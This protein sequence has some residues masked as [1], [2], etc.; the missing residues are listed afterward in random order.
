MWGRRTDSRVT[1]RSP[2]GELLLIEALGH[3]RIA[4]S[5]GHGR[6]TAL[7]LVERLF[8]PIRSRR[9]SRSDLAATSR[10]LNTYQRGNRPD[11]Q[12]MNASLISAEQPGRKRS[13]SLVIN[14]IRAVEG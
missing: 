9:P 6:I 3:L 4:I 13:A 14:N 12:T 11:H 8:L 1:A 5:P 7:L 2:V 10:R